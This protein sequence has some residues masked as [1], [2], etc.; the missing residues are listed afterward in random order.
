MIRIF[1]TLVRWLLRLW[2]STTFSV[3][4]HAALALAAWIGLPLVI[5]GESRLFESSTSRI[6]IIGLLLGH[7]AWSLVRRRKLDPLAQIADAGT[8]Q[9]AL[10]RVS[11]DFRSRARLLRWYSVG[12]LLLILVALLG[13]MYI[14]NG[15]ERSAIDIENERLRA[16]LEEKSKAGEALYLAD[17]SISAL[18]SVMATARPIESGPAQLAN[19]K[20][21]TSTVAAARE[22]LKLLAQDR[23]SAAAERAAEALLGEVSLRRAIKNAIRA[24]AEQSNDQGSAISEARAAVWRIADLSKVDEERWTRAIKDI[25]QDCDI[26]C[27]VTRKNVAADN[28][29]GIEALIERSMKRSDNSSDFTFLAST[30]STKIGSAAILL[31]L[32]QILVNVYRYNVRL[33]AFYDARADG[34]ELATGT[35]DLPLDKLI[36]ALSPDGFDFG[37]APPLPIQ[38]AAELVKEVLSAGKN[39]AAKAA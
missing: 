27:L 24:V 25:S 37:K 14:F 13:G 2:R 1:H 6:V 10:Q 16:L 9:S 33:A 18:R 3:L 22:R 7:F 12:S 28:L 31:F 35:S 21:S 20:H 11:A 4:I 19:T 36:G 5:F 15:A 26:D 30:L 38:V 8:V 17:A 23:P 29:K 32:V 39:V 34:L